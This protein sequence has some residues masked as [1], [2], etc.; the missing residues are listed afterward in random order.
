MR[1]LFLGDVVGRPGRRAVTERLPGLRERWQL[2]AVVINGE[3]SAGGFGITEAICAELLDAGADAVTL[4]N[5]SW[6]QREALVFIARQPRLIRP[7]NFPAGTPGRG[8]NLVDLRDGRRLLVVNALGRL[9]M[10]ALDDPFSALDREVGLCPLAQ[11]A[12]AILVDIHAEATSEKQAVGYNLDGRVSMVVGTHTHVP[13]ADHRIL[14]AGTAYLSDAG[15]C[16]DYESILGLQREEPIRRF[17]EK[18]PGARA[19]VATGEGTLCGFAV[20]TDDATGL[21]VRAAAVRVGPTLTESLP[22]FWE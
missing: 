19:E 12:D 10:E 1:I 6:D 21:A 18:V 20:E 16:G 22:A 4:G 7:C 11:V 15:M 8:A 9:F 14:P 13:T 2:D 5:H 3:N 17:I